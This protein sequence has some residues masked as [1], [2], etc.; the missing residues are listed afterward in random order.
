MP[1]FAANLSMMFT[2]LDFL[3]R[4]RAAANCGFAGVEFQFPY[5]W[6]PGQL[7]E[8]L[9]ANGLSQALFNLP[10]GG[11]EAG[12]RGLAAV[13]GREAEFRDGLHRA[14]DYA[15]ALR[16]EQVHAMAGIVADEGRRAAAH[17]CFVE[18]LKWAAAVA[19]ERAVRV[20]IEPINTR[21]DMPGYFLSTTAQARRVIEE[22]GSDNL[23]LQCDLYHVQIMNGN[24]A[25]TITENLPLIRHFQI[26]GVPGRHEPDHGEINYSFLFSL[27]DSLGYRGWIGCE[28][29]P[30]GGTL[31]GLGWAFD[32]GIGGHGGG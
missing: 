20:L 18:N 29:R 30:A 23:F 4:F 7:A 15:E 26:A 17:E 13:P 14:L 16:C 5:R 32:Y 8:R 6:P 31:D 11:P 24:L 9:L 3:E 25:E 22:V 28:Y 19:A 21:R 12:E 2:E 1:K 10:P 27:I